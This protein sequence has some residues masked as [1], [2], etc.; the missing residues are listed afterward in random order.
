MPL[1]YIIFLPTGGEPTHPIVLPPNQSPVDP[2]YGVPAPPTIWPS[3]GYPAHPIYYPPGIW[4]GGNVPMPTPPIAN[5]PGAPGFKPPHIMNPIPPIIWPDPPE[6]P[7]SKPP[8][9][10]G[11]SPEHPINLP[12]GPPP[13]GFHWELVFHPLLGGWSWALVQ[14]DPPKPPPPGYN[15]PSGGNVPQPVK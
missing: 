6:P 13:E 11:G 7:I 4:G 12:P 2:G 8:E 10:P 1:A 5:V 9:P 3:P 15:P 14:G